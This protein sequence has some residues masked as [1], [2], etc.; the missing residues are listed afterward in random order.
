MGGL[1]GEDA[2]FARLHDEYYAEPDICPDCDEYEPECTCDVSLEERKAEA[3]LDRQIAN[4]EA[5]AEYE[6]EKA[7]WAGM[8]Y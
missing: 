7:H 2:Y 6:A 4:A 1:P 5:K 3:E 8:D